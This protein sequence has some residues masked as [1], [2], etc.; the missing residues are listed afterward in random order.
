MIIFLS[1]GCLRGPQLKPA[2]ELL[3]VRLG[4]LLSSHPG[5][6]GG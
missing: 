4:Q 3:L 6:T 2:M 5:R 1:P